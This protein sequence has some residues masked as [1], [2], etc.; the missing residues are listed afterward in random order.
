M[1]PLKW[2][3]VLLLNDLTTLSL[4]LSSS[5][6]NIAA[7]FLN[8]ESFLPFLPSLL[9]RYIT[10]VTTINAFRKLRVSDEYHNKYINS[11]ADPHEKG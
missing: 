10:Q 6:P 3:L 4:Y 2:V 8:A 9:Q 7:A 11:V 1:V 5:S